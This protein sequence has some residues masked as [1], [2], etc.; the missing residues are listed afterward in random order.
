MYYITHS[1]N[2]GSSNKC[3]YGNNGN[4]IVGPTSG[5]S[6]DKVSLL[7]STELTYLSNLISHQFEDV[8]PFI[9]CCKG[10]PSSC[11]TYYQRRPSDDGSAFSPPVPG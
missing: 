1:G 4:L 6:V 7:G 8:L 11:D 3:C 2:D 9:F 10:T 5:G